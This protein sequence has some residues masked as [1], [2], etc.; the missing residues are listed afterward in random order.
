MNAITILKNEKLMHLCQNLKFKPQHLKVN[1][2]NAK[3]NPIC[4]VVALLTLKSLN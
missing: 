4:L 1:P 3:L 2:L